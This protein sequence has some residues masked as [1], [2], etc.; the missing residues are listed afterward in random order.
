MAER[1]PNSRKTANKAT[2]SGKPLVVYFSEEQADRLDV[3]ARS[4]RVSKTDIVR[5][6]VQR[7]LDAMASDQLDLPLGL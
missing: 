1:S 3:V 5:V 2:R 4:R 6:A 7:L